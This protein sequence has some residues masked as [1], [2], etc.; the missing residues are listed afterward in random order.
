MVL[1]FFSASYFVLCIYAA[2]IDFETLTIPNWLN[3]WLAFLFFP[4]LI[5][6]EPGWQITGLHLLSGLIAFILMLLLFFTKVI[7]GGDA[8]M[9][10]AVMLWLGPAGFSPF[11][12][13]TAVIGGL[14]TIIVVLL[15]ALWPS[16]I[17]PG[18][19]V[20][21]LG[22]RGSVPYGIAIAAGAVLAAPYSPL[23]KEFVSEISNLY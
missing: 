1:Y 12:V 19:G 8:K 15:R 5:L 13:A 16:H 14:L 20:A 22:Q 9:V 7:G 3:G 21:T 11:I 10:P 6:A 23:L 4:A 2:L 17:I 18:F